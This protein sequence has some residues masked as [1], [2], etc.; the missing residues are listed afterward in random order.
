M[1]VVVIVFICFVY[2]SSELDEFGWQASERASEQMY[3]QF[4]FLY[5]TFVL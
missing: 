4:Y 2:A 3:Y 1:C 5:A